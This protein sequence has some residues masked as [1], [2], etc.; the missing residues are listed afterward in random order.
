MKQSAKIRKQM[1]VHFD[2]DT[3]RIG[4]YR[5]CAVHEIPRTYCENTEL[6]FYVDDG[7]TVFLLRLQYSSEN[8]IHFF[9]ADKITLIPYLIVQ[10]PLYC[11]IR[12][13]LTAVL[14]QLHQIDFTGKEKHVLPYIG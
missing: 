10:K 9:P 14:K 4:D 11:V 5:L 12:Q 7:Q 3:F 13:E 1:A 8:K 6:D 2:E